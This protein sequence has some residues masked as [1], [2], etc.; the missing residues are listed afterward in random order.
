MKDVIIKE[1]AWKKD[2]LS[3]GITDITMPAKRAQALSLVDL[4]GKY[5][6]AINNDDLDASKKLGLTSIKKYQRGT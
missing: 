6:Q 2:G 4:A 5:V 1:K 3:V